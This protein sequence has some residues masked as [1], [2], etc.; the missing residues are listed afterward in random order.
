MAADAGPNS[1]AY[2]ASLRQKL[3]KELFDNNDEGSGELGDLSVSD[4]VGGPGAE[5]ALTLQ[6]VDQDLEEFQNHDII[7]GILEQG[8]VLTEYAR[9]VDDKLRQTE[10]DSIAVRHVFGLWAHAVLVLASE[11]VG[12]GS[13][14]RT[15]VC[16][17]QLLANP[18]CMP[19]HTA[20][21]FS[22]VHRN[23]RRT[24]LQ[25]AT[26]W[27]RCMIRCAATCCY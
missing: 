20:S 19:T 16:G 25:R 6:D 11:G 4:L 21:Q 13:H 22:S 8:R 24:T 1:Q 2:A 7:R 3:L 26:A 5:G 14:A 9:D 12:N 10:M 15:R 23:T 17:G 27:S 18:M